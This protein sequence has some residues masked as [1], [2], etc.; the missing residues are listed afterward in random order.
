MTLLI[1]ALHQMIQTMGRLSLSEEAGL[2]VMSVQR[3]LEGFGSFPQQSHCNSWCHR[4]LEQYTTAQNWNRWGGMK[5]PACKDLPPGVYCETTNAA[6]LLIRA[7]LEAI[8][9]E[10]QYQLRGLV[11]GRR[12][13]SHHP[14]RSSL[15]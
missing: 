9:M 10:Y 4:N 1:G 12:A 15:V 2:T 11:Y 6:N 8:D 7:D 14:A 5:W 13:A 3:S